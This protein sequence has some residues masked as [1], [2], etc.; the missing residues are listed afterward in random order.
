MANYP[1]GR[2]PL[3][4]ER[5]RAF[6]GQTVAPDRVPVSI[7]HPLPPMSE[8]L[9]QRLGSCTCAAAAHL[10]NFNLMRQRRERYKTIAD[11]EDKDRGLYHWVTN[12]DPFRG[13]YPPNDTGSSVL[14]A[15]KGAV[16]FGWAKGYRWYLGLDEVIAGLPY[17]PIEVGTDWPD[18]MF[19]L[20]RHGFIEPTG[21]GWG[22]VGHAYV[23]YGMNTKQRWFGMLN[24]WRGWGIKGSQ[25]AKISFD[26][27][28]LLLRRD[29]EAM[30]LESWIPTDR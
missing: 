25:R 7:F 30:R 17:G 11:V 28:D 5:S 21:A 20:N 29:G 10:K 3:F 1:T 19:T 24:T 14:T 27:M 18:G 8:R 26:H 22:Q 6:R 4:D 13:A 23:L 9:N 12:N 15:A 16:H 2:I